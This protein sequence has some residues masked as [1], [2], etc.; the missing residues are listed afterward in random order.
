M[1]ANHPFNKR[2]FLECIVCV[3]LI[4]VACEDGG[5][6][7]V[8]IQDEE[9]PMTA[10]TLTDSLG[11]Y[12]EALQNRGLELQK[13][14]KIADI[15]TTPRTVVY[16]NSEE[17]IDADLTKFLTQFKGVLVVDS[18]D[19]YPAES[20]DSLN[21]DE[22]QEENRPG[23]KVAQTYMEL[24]SDVPG[25]VA[26]FAPG[27]TAIVV[28]MNSESFLPLK[29]SEDGKI[30]GGSMDE[31]EDLLYLDA[32]VANNADPKLQPRSALGSVAVYSVQ[33]DQIKNGYRAVAHI[34]VQPYKQLN[35][36]QGTIWRTT[37]DVWTGDNFEN[38]YVNSGRKCGIYPDNEA[39]IF[40]SAKQDDGC[41]KTTAY[42]VKHGSFVSGYGARS[43]PAYRPSKSF[44]DGGDAV[45][46]DSNERTYYSGFPLG[47]SAGWSPFSGFSLSASNTF[48]WETKGVKREKAWEGFEKKSA[49]NYVRGKTSSGT[50]INGSA[51]RAESGIKMKFLPPANPPTKATIQTNKIYRGFLGGAFNN[52]TDWN[53]MA[54]NNILPSNLDFCQAYN[55]KISKPKMSWEGFMPTITVVHEYDPNHNSMLNKTGYVLIKAG[56][57]WERQALRYCY[58][59]TV[60]CGDSTYRRSGWRVDGTGKLSDMIDPTSVNSFLA[61]SDIW[62]KHDKFI[63]R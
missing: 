39:S 51:Q 17:A 35:Q 56:L 7:D 31:M 22:V 47:V 6:I 18:N 2:R 50:D 63:F 3:S 27:G 13:I 15:P 14:G 46:I 23:A 49:F 54:R 8:N 12:G 36:N 5:M 42:V 59:G 53:T 62:V 1:N 16:M 34:Y 37:T 4:A 10:F 30:N 43:V 52:I 61:Y 11:A 28:S 55:K 32:F 20:E 9:I 25:E 26:G 41:V 29:F 38:C 21:G 40:S 24:M 57:L 60:P 58:S 45:A 33:L 19:L 48:R 44:W